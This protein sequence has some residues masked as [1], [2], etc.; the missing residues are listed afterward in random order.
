MGETYAAA[1][2]DIEAGDAAVARITA[3]V[4][5]TSRPEVIGGIGGFGGLFDISS[6]PY[7]EPVLV[8]AT[9]GVGT[10]ALVAA[11]ARRY[12]TI[13]LD[14][15]AMCVDDLVC[16]GAEPLFFLDYVSVGRVAPDHI[17]ALVSGIA[18]GCRQVGAALIGGEIAEHPGVIPDG[19]FDLV[20]FAVGVVER[21]RALRGPAGTPGDALIALPSPGLRSNGYSLARRLVFDLAGLGIDDPAW[22]GADTTVADELLAPSVIY[23]PA[24]LELMDAIDVVG[25]AHITGGGIPGNLPRALA[26]DVHAVI[27]RSSWTPPPI[28]GALRR[29][30]DVATDEMDRV[31]NQGV[32]MIVVVPAPRSVEAIAMLEEAGHRAWQIGRLEAGSGPV[33]YID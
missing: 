5:S 25:V 33:R 20:G 1:G 19:E 15:V 23:T 12:D 18:D 29:I 30:G 8:S 11:A 14:L 26:A 27:D 16:G 22:P 9:D 21:R 13:G 4:E 32:G 2:V 7:D 24:V 6:L 17:E 10:K 3:H 28:F 31:F